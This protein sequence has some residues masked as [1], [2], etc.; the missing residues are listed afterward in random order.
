MKRALIIGINDYPKNPLFGCVNDAK[1][2][3]E[4]L[5]RNGD[6]VGKLN[7]QCELLV[8]GTTTVTHQLLK[9]K[10]TQ[11]FK[12]SCDS[13][14]L[15]YSGHGS[16]D[17]H[18][19]YL[20]PTD[21]TKDNPGISFHDIIELVNHAPIDDITIILD[22]CYSGAFAES[23]SEERASASLR[24]GVS[25]LTASSGEEFAKEDGTGGIFTSIV[26][27]ALEGQAA[28]VLGNITIAGIY[29]LADKLL[30]AWEQRPM[31]KANITQLRT[32]R[33][34]KGKTTD[35]KLL[36][37]KYF[38]SDAAAEL[39]LDQSYESHKCEVP[40]ALQSSDPQRE[41]EL[42]ELQDFRAAGLVEPVEPYTNLYSVAIHSGKCRLTPEGRFY[43]NM[44][45]KKKI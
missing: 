7:Y 9:Q 43:W 12:T 19:G 1:R 35:R 28:D 41:S 24:K 22:C 8:S 25:I 14:L 2:M 6:C 3:E 27:S 21:A 37:L 18:G 17:L 5:E 29:S 23:N 31:F 32:I 15:Y 45:R 11:L 20:I 26:V 13:A 30:T 36:R 33:R 38:F 10:I 42:E 4:V 34:V 40:E 39:Q 44:V 16:R